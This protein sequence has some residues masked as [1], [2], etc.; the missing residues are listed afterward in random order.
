MVGMIE[1]D[2][3]VSVVYEK[4]DAA[5]FAA[6]YEHVWH[7]VRWIGR[8]GEN[9]VHQCHIPRYSMALAARHLL[10]MN[11]TRP[12][13]MQS[14]PLCTNLNQATLLCIRAQNQFDIDLLMTD[15]GLPPM[16]LKDILTDVESIEVA[17]EA[18]VRNAEGLYLLPGEQTYKGAPVMHASRALIEAVAFERRVR[19]ELDA[20]G[21]F[22]LYSAFCTMVDYPMESDVW[23]QELAALVD[24][25]RQFDPASFPEDVLN[26]ISDAQRD[27]MNRPIWGFDNV[28][29]EEDALG[30][31]LDGMKTLSAA[32]RAQVM[33]LGGMQDSG[34]LLPM[35]TATHRV[36]YERYIGLLTGGYQPDS[37]EEQ[38]IRSAVAIVELLDRVS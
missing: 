18:V 19:G 16:L 23:I 32:E 9:Q 17:G 7:F 24:Q 12:V 11:E 5:L 33:L 1:A 3:D 20:T 25:Q 10:Q 6:L 34:L 36:S 28:M 15:E 29:A 30:I 38:Q 14:Q 35:A 13:G 26:G 8:D 31:V 37:E 22:G 4:N 2:F 27:V 21:T